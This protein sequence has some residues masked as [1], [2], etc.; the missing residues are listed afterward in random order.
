MTN[1][2]A[3][4]LVVQ[5]GEADSRLDAFVHSHTDAV[6]R[7]DARY[8]CEFGAVALRG[9]AASANT[10]V[11]V[12]D[13]VAWLP[14][15]ATWTL[16]L[17]MPVVHVDD[18]LIVL[19]KP[20]NLG[21]QRGPLDDDCLA[22]R[23]GRLFPG[24]R[25]V[26]GLDR[27]GS[28]LLLIARHDAAERAVA[29]AIETNAVSRE[30]VAVVHGDVE[31]DGFTIDHALRQTEEPRANRPKVVVDAA[32]QPARTHVR[33]RDRRPGAALLAVRTDTSLP[34][35]IRA[36]LAA[37]GHPLLG[38]LRYG[39]ASAN[40]HARSTFGVNRLMLRATRL[41][42]PHP[43]SGERFELAVCHEADFA[44]MFRALR[45]E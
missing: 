24:A 19:D 31:R 21:L 35:Q 29:N 30:Y 9:V 12:G 39:N 32:G 22:D 7:R 40:V 43:G 2:V 14:S 41:T 38:D 15:T 6:S 20:P 27:G 34:H 36:H 3:E 26:Q 5:D 8:L 25:L 10:R 4:S 44:R 16:R 18:D 17:G 11:R 28:G 37:A 45:E 13:V 33:V 1:G 42:F 23:V